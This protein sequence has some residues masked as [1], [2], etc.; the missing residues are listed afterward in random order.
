MHAIMVAPTQSAERVALT[1]RKELEKSAN[2][3]L[4]ER[5]QEQMAAARMATEARQQREHPMLSTP[6][7]A[8]QSGRGRVLGE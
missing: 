5:K 6:M 8:P 1:G 2:K 3:S 7:R 4:L